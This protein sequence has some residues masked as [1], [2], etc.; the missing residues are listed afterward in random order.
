VEV[1]VSGRPRPAVGSARTTR[2]SS[3]ACARSSRMPPRPA[4]VGA[5]P[6][7]RLHAAARAATS[8]ASRRP[9]TAM[10]APPPDTWKRPL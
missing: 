2:R 8:H 7:G 6:S 9:R 3:I 1:I 10:H 5:G 4:L